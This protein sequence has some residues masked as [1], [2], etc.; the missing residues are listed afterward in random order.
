MITTDMRNYEYYKL[1]TVDEYGQ[2]TITN[3]AIGTVKMA[4]NT[5]SQSIQDN[6]LYKDCNYIGLTQ[7]KSVDD[8][9]II[10]YGNERLKVNYINSKGRYI[11]VFMVNTNG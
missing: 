6:I 10:K 7:D 9:Y 2:S 3:D 8:T 4:I 11:Q 1:G 5:T